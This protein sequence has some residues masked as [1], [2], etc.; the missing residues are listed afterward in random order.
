MVPVR[1]AGDE[2][3]LE[4]GEDPL[5]RLALLRRSRRQRRAD[6]AGADAGED[7]IARRIVEVIR[8]PV[9]ETMRLLTEVVQATDSTLRG[10]R[11]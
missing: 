11:R 7:R 6:V 5:E 9:G 3:P 1:E 2:D 4:V 10:V 8:D